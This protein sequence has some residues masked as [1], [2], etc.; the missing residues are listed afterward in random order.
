MWSA[1]GIVPA[2]RW[3]VMVTALWMCAL[4]SALAQTEDWLVL[5]TSTDEAET[6]WM[7]PTV[8]AANRAL[9]R[10]GIG[11]WFPGSAVSAFHERGSSEAPAP[12]DE[13]ISAWSDRATSAFRTIVLGDREL[14]LAELEAAQGFAEEN[15]VVLNRDPKT[16]GLVLDVCLYLARAYHD[17]GKLDAA[18]RQ[19]RDC[20]RLSPATTPNPRVHPPSIID[21]YTAAQQPSPARGGSLIVE[22]EPAGCDLRINGNL[23]GKTPAA[24]DDLY[25]G[26]YQAQVECRP[27]EVGRVHR[28]E[29]PQGP[30]SLFVIDPF[31]RVVRS[32]TLIYL[33]YEEEP[34]PQELG[35][36]AREVARSLPASAVI[37]VSL[38]S[39]EVLQLEVER[40]TQTA[41][42]VVRLPT[43]PDGP[44]QELMNQAVAD[45]LAGRCADFTDGTRREVDC[46]TGQPIV[47]APVDA[48]DSK[49]VR[50]RSLF[51][52]GVTLASLGTASLASGWSL[53][54]V[55]RS[56]GDNWISDPNNLSLQAKWLDLQTPI[57]VTGAVGGGFLVAAMPMVLP[58][59]A[60]TPWWAWLN[61][62][63]GLAAAVGSIVSAATAA[64]KPAQSCELNGQ[65]PTSCVNRKRDTDRAILLGVTAAPLLTMPLVYL[66]RRGERKSRVEAQPRLVVGRQGGF[67]GVSGSF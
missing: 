5:P 50:P 4:P 39:P 16:A 25:P 44:E 63:L 52:T 28:L 2:M 27:D 58:M 47:P 22:S 67:V 41:S 45:L 13:E 20:V 18:E 34:D 48:V 43:I 7:E 53:F 19:V 17:T 61:G 40:T 1:W 3:A 37:V 15:L 54:L 42:A 23:V 59:H 65:D 57:I 49:R 62:G 38:V 36:H 66:L 29:V 64:P 14:A 56:A 55:R 10:Q 9:R 51:I 32:S 60:K 24:A 21:L 12:S 33:Q 11:V 35:R 46:E 31:E 30:R 26:V 6:P 8:Q